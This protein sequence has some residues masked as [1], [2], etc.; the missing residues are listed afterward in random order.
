M[1]ETEAADLKRLFGDGKGEGLVVVGVE[2][3]A[4]R[5]GL[6]VVS[7]VWQQEDAH[8]R[9]QRRG[10]SWRAW[11]KIASLSDADS[12][13]LC[14]LVEL[15]AEPESS[16]VSLWVVGDV[17]LLRTLVQLRVEAA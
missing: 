6:D 2:R 13:S 12:E 14:V 9:V 5:L 15:D 16:D 4:S 11:R 10:G 1:T 3:L 7:L 8:E 17:A